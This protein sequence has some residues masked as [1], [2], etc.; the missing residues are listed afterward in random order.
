[1]AKIIPLIP[2]TQQKT[3]QSEVANTTDSYARITDLLMLSATDRIELCLTQD[4][5][6]TQIYT[7]ILT[8][9]GKATGRT[10][11]KLFSDQAIVMYRNANGEAL[12]GA[13]VKIC[14]G[15]HA[16]WQTIEHDN[17][18]NDLTAQQNYLSHVLIPAAINRAISGL[19]NIFVPQ[20]RSD[21]TPALAQ[22]LRD[23]LAALA[24]M[25]ALDYSYASDELRE[26]A[27]KLIAP[28]KP[29]NQ[30]QLN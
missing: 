17:P 12:P 25:H 9:T 28:Q 3:Q 13:I 23:L 21:L 16:R 8:C 1:M 22:S 24:T 11:N 14:P 15:R 10:F 20:L 4:A 19:N 30:V 27:A 18:A 2:K 26:A 5:R 7:E 6:Y 29:G